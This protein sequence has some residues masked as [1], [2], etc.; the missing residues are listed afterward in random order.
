LAAALEL[1]QKSVTKTEDCP[2][3]DESRHEDDPTVTFFTFQK[4]INLLSQQDG[5]L[6]DS[7]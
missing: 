2:Q 6:G 7:S 3:S 4:R 5:G 1:S